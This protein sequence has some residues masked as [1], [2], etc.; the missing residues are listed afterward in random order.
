[1]G[2]IKHQSIWGVYDIALLTSIIIKNITINDHYQPFSLVTVP[3]LLSRGFRTLP[4]GNMDLRSR[5]FAL[6]RRRVPAGVKSLSQ[7]QVGATGQK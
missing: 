6:H 5:V 1:M 4:G 2:G 7:H 3:K